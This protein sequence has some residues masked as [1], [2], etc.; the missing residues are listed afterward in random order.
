MKDNIFSEKFILLL[1]YVTFNFKLFS[2]Q[3]QRDIVLPEQLLRSCI[4]TIVRDHQ[5]HIRNGAIL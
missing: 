5:I 2:G 4:Q 3:H 1:F